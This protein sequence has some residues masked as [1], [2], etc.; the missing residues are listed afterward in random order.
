M[1]RFFSC[2]MRLFGKKIAALLLTLGLVAVFGNIFRPARLADA[3]VRT[4]VGE[5]R[6]TVV[7]DAG[8]GGFDGGTVSLYGTP[9]KEVNLAVALASCRFLQLFGFRV[10]LTRSEDTALAADKKQDM[11]RRLEIIR[12]EPDAVFLSIHQNHFTEQKYF[13][14]QMFYGSRREQESRQLAAVL[15]DRFRE[16]LNMQ[17]N[18]QI[19]PAPADL[20]LFKNAP[21]P[22]VLVE[23]GFLSNPEEAKLL[24]NPDYQGQIAFTIAQ[25]VFEF[26]AQPPA[27]RK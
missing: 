5:L 11:H 25:A 2:R 13:G 10:V 18:R 15:Q 22:C 1:K 14:A 16:N 4:S 20:Y 23:C 6:P 27:E 19:K 3:L 24:V 12:R 8:H 17:N 7:L 26:Q 9:E 21:Q